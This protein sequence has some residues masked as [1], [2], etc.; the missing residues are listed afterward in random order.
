[1]NRGNFVGRLKQKVYRKVHLRRK[2]HLVLLFYL[3]KRL[4]FVKYG[5]MIKVATQVPLLLPREG[6]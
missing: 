6:N 2:L 3:V 1:M 5:Y 4:L